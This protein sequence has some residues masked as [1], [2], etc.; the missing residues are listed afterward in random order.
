MS[1]YARFDLILG[2]GKRYI[3][4]HGPDAE[5]V[6]PKYHLPGIKGVRRRIEFRD[7]KIGKRHT[8]GLDDLGDETFSVWIEE[9]SPD[10][11]PYDEPWKLGAI[12]VSPR[13]Y[14]LPMM[15]EE[16]WKMAEASQSGCFVT[17]ETH[18]EAAVLFVFTI[19]MEV[20]LPQYPVV[21]ASK[22][23]WRV[24]TQSQRGA[25]AGPRVGGPKT[26]GGR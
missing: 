2:P 7:C 15:F 3:I 20:L 14:L 23:R 17:V 8:S 18:R 11:R 26:S 21:A 5:S 25:S 9:Q 16:F 13:F 1:D 6:L 10:A 4:E 22:K 19:G 12:T 24:V